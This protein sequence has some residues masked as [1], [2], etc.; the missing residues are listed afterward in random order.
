MEVGLR[1]PTVGVGHRPRPRHESRPL[2]AW[3]LV[4]CFQA[5]RAWHTRL[6]AGGT[7]KQLVELQQLH[8]LAS[9][10]RTVEAVSLFEQLWPLMSESE[11]KKPFVWNS[12]LAAFA[13]A[14][15]FEGALAWFQRT[16]KAGVPMRKKA[17]GKMMEAA[18]RAGRIE[19]T[20][21]WMEKL[22]SLGEPD[23]EAVS[24]LIYAYANVGRVQDAKKVLEEKIR[25][26][27]ANLIDYSTVSDAFAKQGKPSQ[28]AEVLEKAK[29]GDEQSFELATRLVTCH[30]RASNISAATKCL[31]NM[32]AAGLELDL[33]AQ[34]AVINALCKTKQLKEARLQLHGMMQSKLEVD[35][36]SFTPIVQLCA[37]SG[38]VQDALAWLEAMRTRAIVPDNA[39]YSVVLNACA[40]ARS[41]TA[42]FQ[43]LNAARVQP[44]TVTM[45]SMI[46]SLAKC[47]DATAVELLEE[48]KQMRLKPSV[49]SY[50]SVVEALGSRHLDKAFELLDEVPDPDLIFY[51]VLLSACAK[52]A[53]ADRAEQV[54]QRLGA[55]DVQSYSA[56][57]HAYA[58][59]GRVEAAAEAIA[60]MQ[61]ARVDPNKFIWSGMLKACERAK[62]PVWAMVTWR[63]LLSFG[64][65]PD[66]LLQSRFERVVGPKLASTVKSKLKAS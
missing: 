52:A 34:N 55:P 13:E 18:A 40:D 60:D 15:D 30:A 36:L 46:N 51:N 39:S 16:E 28:A 64:T 61:E 42:V 48:M 20:E 41:V 23:H 53:D 21:E 24:I 33:V 54:F 17:Y 14:G 56:L 37:T 50:T 44:D 38:H 6:A 66:D 22:R 5:G 49:R 35:A 26:G 65:R 19:L 2:A 32:R 63:N 29:L 31:E 58:G 4:P 43:S 25:E 7:R 1:L 27:T 45:N 57:V 11:Q 3:L 62:D 59:Q 9:E 12:V 47:R 8:R 10:G